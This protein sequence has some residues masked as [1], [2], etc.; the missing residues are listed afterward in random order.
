MPLPPLVLLGSLSPAQP[1]TKCSLLE[2]SISDI[3]VQDRD[4]KVWAEVEGGLETTKSGGKGGQGLA[5]VG[6]ED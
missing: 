4:T 3:S 1:G 6:L 2:Q 5:G